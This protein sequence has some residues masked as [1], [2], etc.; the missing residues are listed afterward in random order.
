MNPFQVGQVNIGHLHDNVVGRF[1]FRPTVDG[2]EA[3]IGDVGRT[4]QTAHLEDVWVVLF[5]DENAPNVIP[6][7]TNQGIGVYA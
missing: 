6:L 1:D 3:G 2:W 7:Q 4:V 5:T